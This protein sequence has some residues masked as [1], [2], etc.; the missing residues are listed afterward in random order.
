LKSLKYLIALP[1]FALA[2]APSLVSQINVFNTGVQ[3]C[4]DLLDPNWTLTAAPAGATLG[5]LYST[6]TYPTWVTP[7]AGSAWI[8]PFGDNGTQP[9]GNYTYREIFTLDSATGN[10]ITGEFAADNSAMMYLNGTLIASTV[11]G[12]LGFEQYTPFSADNSF[13]AGTNTIDI[14]VN[15]AGPSPTGLEVEINGSSGIGTTPEPSSLFL[16]GSG[17]LAL[18]GVVRR[19]RVV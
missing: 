8:N 1:I 18:A 17:V 19:M 5:N 15:N 14:V 3:G 13:L 12:I 9:A 6:P 2:I 11:N 7:S 16:M 4:C 10:S